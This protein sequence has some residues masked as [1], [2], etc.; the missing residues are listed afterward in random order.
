MTT[1]RYIKPIQSNVPKE[2]AAALKDMREAIQQLQQGMGFNG[3]VFADSVVQIVTKGGLIPTQQP[4]QDLEP[5]F[6][7]LRQLTK[8]AQEQAAS[9]NDKITVNSSMAFDALGQAET[10]VATISDL[11]DDLADQADQLVE[12]AE[13]LLDLATDVDLLQTTVGDLSTDFIA[14]STLLDATVS[15][16]DATEDTVDVITAAITSLQAELV[17]TTAFDPGIIWQFEGSLDGWTSNFTLTT[18][19]YFLSVPDDA[20]TYLRSPSGIAIDGRLYT[21]IIARI[22]RTSGTG[23]LGRASYATSGGSAHGI[24]TTNFHLTLATTPTFA[25]GGWVIVVWDMEMLS[26]GGSDWV[27][28]IIDQIQLELSDDAATEFDVDWVAIGRVA[29]SFF[30][31]SLSALTSRVTATEDAITALS[32]DVTSLES[33]ATDLEGDVD[34]V[35]TAVDTLSTRVDATEDSIT[36]QSSQITSLSSR[37]DD[38]EDDIS[39]TST[40]LSGLTTRVEVTEDAISV[41]SSQITSLDSRLDDAELDISAAATAISGLDTRI[42]ATED[43]ITAQSSDITDL[44]TTVNHPTTG[45]AAT[46]TALGSL[47]TRV[48]TAEAGISTNSTAITSLNSAVTNPV[49]GLSANA[50]AINSVQT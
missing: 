38:A 10:N 30:S 33:R 5:F 37:V 11:A 40:A 43:S 31:G 36:T 42:D 24:D 46:S 32:S 39:A 12:Q 17:D 2:V 44:Q 1:L 34:A 41:Q 9:L 13:D 48:T 3:D 14:T 4:Q 21:R 28:N 47:T 18:G 49:T 35:S 26:A 27:D 45:V 7:G 19:D 29:P 15:R 8:A 16:V 23:W 6:E 20:G 25:G 22:R 50:T